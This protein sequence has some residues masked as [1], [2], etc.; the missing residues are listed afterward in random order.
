MMVQQ[1]IR[2]HWVLGCAFLLVVGCKKTETA[3]DVEPFVPFELLDA[4]E[5]PRALLRYTIPDG[6]TTTSTMSF[7]TIPGEKA[8]PMTESGLQRLKVKAVF[9][10]AEL[11][12]DEIRYD[13]EIVDSNAVARPGASGKLLEDIEESAAFLKGT[14]ASIAINDRGNLRSARSSQGTKAVPLR[15]LWIIGNTVS[16]LSVVGLPPEE[17]GIGARWRVRAMLTFYGIKLEQ[18]TT[19]TLIER[20]GDE[21]VLDVEFKRAGEQQVVDFSEDDSSM[22]VESIRATATGQIRLDLKTLGANGTATGAN[23]IKVVIVKDGNRENREISEDYEV[24]ISSTTTVREAGSAT[25]RP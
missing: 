3:A 7:K 4:G 24:Q 18:Q 14:G 15:L 9:G 25:P 8:A 22:E 19:Y 17:V 11:V 1:L 20:T 23:K 13:Y 12:E 10:P 16:N 5:E 21:I 2:G 6:T